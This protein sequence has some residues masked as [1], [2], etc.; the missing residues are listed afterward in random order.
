MRA[1]IVYLPLRRLVLRELPSSSRQLLW[2]APARARLC[3]AVGRPAVR[4]SAVLLEAVRDGHGLGAAEEQ[5]CDRFDF[6]ILSG[7]VQRRAPARQTTGL[8]RPP[9]RSER[10]GSL[11]VVLGVDGGVGADQQSDDSAIAVVRR[12]VQRGDSMPVH[13]GLGEG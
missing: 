6:A 2:R 8:G 13:G 1:G 11:V 10:K 5:F 7:T 9:R 12:Q 4:R 3:C